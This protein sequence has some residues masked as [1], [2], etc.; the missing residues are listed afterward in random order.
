MQTRERVF[1]LGHPDT[2][3]SMANLASTYE[4]QR[5]WEEAEELESQVVESYKKVLGWEHPQTL[6]SMSNLAS[7]L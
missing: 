6:T 1:G 5:R 4:S 7:I 2:L 3:E